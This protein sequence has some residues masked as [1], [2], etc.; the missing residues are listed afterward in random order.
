MISHH[1]PEKMAIFQASWQIVK[2]VKMTSYKVPK[3]HSF[4]LIGQ[5]KIEEGPGKSRSIKEVIK[6]FTVTDQNNSVRFILGQ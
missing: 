2:S 1:N 6:Y 4:K 5:E 3:A